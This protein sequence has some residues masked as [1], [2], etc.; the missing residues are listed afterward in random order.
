MSH[1]CIVFGQIPPKKSFKEFWQQLKFRKQAGVGAWGLMRSRQWSI[2]VDL[3][4][5]FVCTQVVNA[6]SVGKVAAGLLSI[7]TAAMAKVLSLHA[8]EVWNKK[9]KIVCFRSEPIV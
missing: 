8:C 1:S 3:I 5:R 7:L 9:S 2:T 4:P 6:I